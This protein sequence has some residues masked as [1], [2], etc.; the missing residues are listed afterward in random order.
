MLCL[1]GFELFSRWVPLKQPH[2]RILAV[3]LVNNFKILI[4][5]LSEYVLIL[6]RIC[7]VCLIVQK[8]TMISV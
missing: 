3:I 8:E 2:Q 1:S 6:A 7:C 4:V 5:F